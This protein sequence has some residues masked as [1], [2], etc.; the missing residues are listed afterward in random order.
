M[1]INSDTGL[2]VGS[3]S[4]SR[5]QGPFLMSSRIFVCRVWSFMVMR[6]SYDSPLIAHVAGKCMKYTNSRTASW[7][8]GSLFRNKSQIIDNDQ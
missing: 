7:I 1:G 2:L 3:R 5:S 6:R 8:L 4:V